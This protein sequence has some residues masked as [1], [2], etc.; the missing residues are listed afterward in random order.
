M[1]GQRSAIGSLP[2]SINFDYG[3]SSSNVGIDQQIC[4]NNLR[5]P[6]ESRLSDYRIS[7]SASDTFIGSV[8]E[9]GQNLRRWNIGESSS[10]NPQNLAGHDE[11]MTQSGR[12]SS[13][14]ASAG[15]GFRLEDQRHEPTNLGSQAGVNL[16]LGSNQILNGSAFVRSSN[17]SAISQSHDLNEGHFHQVG[18]DVDC[19]NNSKSVGFESKFISSGTSSSDP[20]ASSSGSG[21]YLVEEDDAR[22]GCSPDG[23]RLSCKRKTLEGNGGQASNSGSSFPREEGSMWHAVP[24]PHY[25]ASSNTNVPA[26]LESSAI[27]SPSEQVNARLGLGMDGGVSAD[28]LHVLNGRGGADSSHRNYRLRMNSSLQPDSVSN[29]SYLPFLTSGPGHPDTSAVHQPLRFAHPPIDLMSPIPPENAV[30]LSQSVIL[31]MPTL[32]RNIQALRWNGAPNLRPGSSSNSVAP[33]ER[34][35]TLPEDLNPRSMP[36][37]IVEH[38]I[39][40]PPVEA[41]SSPQNPTN[42]SL[43]GGNVGFSRN[44]AS[45]SRTGSGSGS[46][47]SPGPSWASHHRNS[48]TQYS[49]RLSEYVRRSLL[50]GPEIAGQSSNNSQHRSGPAF[51][52]EGILATGS[53]NQGHAQSYSRSALWVDRQAD[54]VVG[55]PY[56]LRALAAAA[57]G[58]SR[59]VSEIRNVLEIMRRGEGLRFEDVMVFDPSVFFGMADIHDQHRDMRLDVD[60]MSY[61]ELLA[62]EERI[63]N[64]CTGLSEETILSRMN[65]RKYIHTMSDDQAEPEPCCICQEEY[66]DGEDLGTLDCGH[67]FHTDCIKQWLAQKNLCPIC[68]TT[69]LAT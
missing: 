10:S 15:A 62:L 65:Q 20:F 22:P 35:T 68:K 37:N 49:R 41:R 56:S 47:T 66:N 18:D 69:A 57:E 48:P 17:S 67:D 34:D 13:M 55:I 58:R 46:H 53:G 43:G 59:L 36:R 25:D 16:N 31:R 51:S 23:R 4:W 12:S 30:P 44:I 19:P 26:Q 6:A 21:G 9:E 45:S 54:G 29:N 8:S 5:N 61:E 52:Q 24:P 63:G 38:P 14:N 28:N 32:R 40:V 2:D 33:G 11:W 60:N 64:V 27:I 50:S 3:S 39:F 42:W 1:Q 7:A